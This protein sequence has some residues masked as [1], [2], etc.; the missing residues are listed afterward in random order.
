[1]KIV[2]KLSLDKAIESL[3]DGKPVLV[4]D[5]ESRENEI[6]IFILASKMTPDKI[7]LMRKDGGGL[8]C[9]AIHSRIANVLDIPLIQELY[10]YS[11]YDTLRKLSSKDI[12]YDRRSSFSIT[13]NHVNTVT[14]ITDVDRSITIK[15]IGELCREYWYKKINDERLHEMF[16][17]EFRSPGH[18][19]LLRGAE[20]LLSERKGHTELA[21]ALALLANVEPCVAL[22]EMLSDN[23][24]ALSYEEARKYAER[25]GLA[26]LTGKEIEKEFRKIF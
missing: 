12:P 11:S 24:K 4:H 2:I 21:I 15:R 10:I 16:L 6:D 5:S 18:V 3:R 20:G 9:V 22:V 13:V 8:I 14:G 19:H 23:G 7:R 25:N 26:I 17:K 1:V